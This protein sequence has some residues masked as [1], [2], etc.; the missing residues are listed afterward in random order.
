M[1]IDVG[2]NSELMAASKAYRRE[3]VSPS[4]KNI[5]VFVDLLLNLATTAG[6]YF[7]YEHE[8]GCRSMA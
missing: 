3:T 4:M 2:L 6:V 5:A 7:V 1:L 8:H